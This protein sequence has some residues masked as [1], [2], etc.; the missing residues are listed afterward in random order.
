MFPFSAQPLSTFN[1]LYQYISVIN[2]TEEKVDESLRFVEFLL[3]KKVQERLNEIDMFSCFYPVAYE[4][5]NMSNMQKINNFSTISPFNKSEFLLEL[6]DMTIKAY[7]GDE[8]KLNKL[9]K[10]II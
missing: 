2:T 4:N 3:S 8:D 7:N 5:E 10:F 6:K 1:D 9:K